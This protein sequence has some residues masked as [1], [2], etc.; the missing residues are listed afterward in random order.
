MSEDDDLLDKYN[1]I[2]DKVIAYVKKEVDSESA[3][4]KKSF[5]TKIKSYDDEATDFHYEKFSLCKFLILIV[6]KKIL[7]VST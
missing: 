2:W 5:K 6:R 7:K 4:N 1:N 3:Y